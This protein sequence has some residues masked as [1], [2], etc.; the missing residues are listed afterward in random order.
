MRLPRVFKD[1]KAEVDLEKAFEMIRYAAEHGVDY[2]DTAFGYHNQTSE[3]V[4][5]EALAGG[6]REKVKI[7]TKLPPR[8]SKT[9]GDIRKHLE[10]TLKKLRT[11]YMDVYLIHGIGAG[12]WEEVKRREIFKEYEKFKAEGLIKAI[13]FSYHGGP[14]AFKEMLA[15]YPW[16]MCM[17]Q[18]NLLDVDKEVTAE[19][20]TLAGEK[21]CALAVME[22]L[23]GGGLATAPKS[24]QALFESHPIKRTPVEWAFYHLINYPQISVI[25]SG[26]SSLEQIK[27][28][29]EIFSRPDAKPGCLSDKD[30][31]LLAKVRAAYD[32]M[33]AI[34]CTACEY[35]M[36][37]AQNVGIAAAFTQYNDGVKFEN[38]DQPRRSYWFGK[39]AL[40]I[41]AGRCTECGDC[42]PKCP[43]GID[44]PA[45]LKV[46]R[47]ALDGWVE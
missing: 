39:I 36:P 21:G 32:S 38:F 34:P 4:L 15:E 47:K 13:G 41:D 17:V 19:A 40:G 28:N 27:E 6:L 20:I 12:S 35:C 29:I 23:R 3:S 45:Q 30:K 5:G 2:F 18:Q 25:I 42:S 26:M 11:D 16:E 24:V 10:N 1:G 37:C 33:Q 44:I 22:P 46:A 7:V 8:E 43:Q 9:A 31:E 14:A